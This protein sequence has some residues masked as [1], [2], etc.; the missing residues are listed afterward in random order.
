MSTSTRR[1]PRRSHTS[2]RP[3]NRHSSPLLSLF[4][5][6][7][8]LSPP[9]SLL[10]HLSLSLSLSLSNSLS[11]VLHFQFSSLF[12]FFP[13][14]LLDEQDLLTLR[15]LS[16]IPVDDLTILLNPNQLLTKR[17]LKDA[18]FKLKKK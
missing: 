11:L 14:L 4:P 6:S 16:S 12:F 18:G 5:L 3:A 1:I 8:S 17:S 9:S 2:Y 7:S 10:L 13:L 15:K